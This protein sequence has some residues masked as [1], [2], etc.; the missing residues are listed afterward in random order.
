M[1]SLREGRLVF[2]FPDDGSD[3]AKYD[4]WSFYRNQFQRVCRRAKAVDFVFVETART[5]LIEAKDYRHQRRTKVVDLPCEV[6]AKIRDTLAGLA[7][8][9]CNANDEDERRIADHALSTPSIGVVLHLEQP[10]TPS[11]LF[12]LV[13]DRAGLTQKLKQLLKPVDPHPRIVDRH[14]LHPSMRWRV[15]Q[16]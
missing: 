13:A 14:S 3:V 7:A 4:D 16:P 6:A 5:W 9:R 12:P 11:K 2:N 15:T 1:P 8:C 10:A